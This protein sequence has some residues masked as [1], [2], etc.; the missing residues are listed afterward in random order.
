[1]ARHSKNKAIET[2]EHATVSH[3]P[4]MRV[5]LVDI[6]IVTILNIGLHGING[7]ADQALVATYWMINPQY[8]DVND[9]AHVTN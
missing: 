9:Q 4:N 8:S 1:L 7:L 2:A 3:A 5:Q 6:A